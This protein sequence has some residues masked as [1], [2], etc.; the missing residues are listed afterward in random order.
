LPWRPT[1]RL[2]FPLAC[3]GRLALTARS[4]GTHA[5]VGDHAPIHSAAGPDRIVHQAC[6]TAVAGR[7]AVRTIGQ[8]SEHL[9]LTEAELQIL[10]CVREA[11]HA[12]IDQT[13][14]ATALAFSPAQVSACVEKMRGRG[15]ISHHKA[16]GDRRRRLWQLASGGRTVIEQL[17]QVIGNLELAALQAT[18]AVSTSS[19]SRE[20]AA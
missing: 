20:A 18:T 10:W 2:S 13:T 19:V 4:G 16:P 8:W 15:L 12:G 14:L 7:R 9:G 3:Q 6:L 1:H 11:T 17:T 5:H